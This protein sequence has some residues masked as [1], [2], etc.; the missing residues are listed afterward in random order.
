M[1]RYTAIPTELQPVSA[2]KRSIEPDRIEYE[3]ASLAQIPVPAGML[4]R[5]RIGDCHRNA[6]CVTVAECFVLAIEVATVAESPRMLPSRS[7]GSIEQ[8]FRLACHAMVEGFRLP[9]NTDRERSWE[10][11]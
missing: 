3:R 8:A 9:I 5:I 10:L 4:G 6:K 1:K 7:E 2:V 11:I